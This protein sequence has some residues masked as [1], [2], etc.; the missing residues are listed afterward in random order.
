VERINTRYVRVT[1]W[2]LDPDTTKPIRVRVRIAGRNRTYLAARDRRDVARQFP[3]HG[4]R[5]GFSFLSR[6]S[7]S[8]RV[9]V[10]ALDAE[11]DA[12]RQLGCRRA[13]R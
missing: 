5:H 10:T 8:A 11:A 4:S 7:S 9:C 6:A 12:H 3:A 13:P 2:A 1:G